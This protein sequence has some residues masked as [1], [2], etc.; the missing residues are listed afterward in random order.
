MH[1]DYMHTGLG[2]VD[3]LTKAKVE[4]GFAS[5]TISP[6]AYRAWKDALAKYEAELKA[7][8]VARD[9]MKRTIS[10]P[11]EAAFKPALEKAQAAGP[12]GTQAVLGIQRQIQSRIE[13]ELKKKFLTP[14]PRPPTP[15]LGAGAAPTV[16]VAPGVL[17]APVAPV[18]PAAAAAAAAAAASGFPIVPVLAVAGIGAFFF[19]R[20][21]S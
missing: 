10:G 1:Y 13:S 21:K 17:V 15:P 2:S 7:W 6:G 4:K 3:V 18:A 19:L 11:I 9:D 14:E 20:K 5:G 8:Q 12:I 16:S